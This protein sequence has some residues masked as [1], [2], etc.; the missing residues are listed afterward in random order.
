MYPRSFAWFDMVKASFPDELWYSNLRVTRGTSKYILH[1]IDDEI[2]RENTPMRKCEKLAVTYVKST[3][4]V[5][6]TGNVL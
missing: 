2:S 4:T 5:A 6:I 1:E 3:T